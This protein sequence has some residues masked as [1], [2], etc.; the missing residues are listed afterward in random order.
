MID[1][2]VVP[3]D[4]VRFWL[5]RTGLVPQFGT[6]IS[7]ELLYGSTYAAIQPDDGGAV[8]HLFYCAVW[9]FDL[10]EAS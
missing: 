5:M 7:V 4:R 8:A 1:P 2:C 9:G 3:G 6:V 10:L